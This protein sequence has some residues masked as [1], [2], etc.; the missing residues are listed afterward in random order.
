[1]RVTEGAIEEELKKVKIDGP[2]GLI[3]PEPKIEPRATQGS[4]PPEIKGNA[5]RPSEIIK[6]A[7]IPIADARR[8]AKDKL[9]FDL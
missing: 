7:K 9:S 2:V 4:G 3:E 1:M 6:I 5:A 8:T